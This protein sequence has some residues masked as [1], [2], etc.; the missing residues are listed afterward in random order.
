MANDLIKTKRITRF[1][2]GTPGDPGFPGRP[3][4][5]ARVTKFKYDKR[6]VAGSSTM[7]I[8]FERVKF[9]TG[10]SSIVGASWTS[11]L[12]VLRGMVG[13]PTLGAAAAHYTERL[14]PMVIQYS[15]VERLVL[16]S[17]GYSL[18]PFVIPV[19]WSDAWIVEQV[20]EVTVIPAKPAIP[21]RP[22]KPGTPP[23]I[24]YDY[25]LGW[26]GVARSIRALPQGWIGTVEFDVGTVVGAMVG[27]I[28]KP[29][30]DTIGAYG[31]S[32][33][34]SGVAIG[35]GKICSVQRGVRDTTVAIPVTGTDHVKGVVSA[36]GVEWFANDQFITRT[37]LNTKGEVVLYA[38]LYRGDDTVL[39]PK[40]TDGLPPDPDIEPGSAK[41]KLY[42]A[43]LKA[44]N[45]E[46]VRGIAKLSPLTLLASDYKV[47][48][49]GLQMRAVRVG[50]TPLPRGRVSIPALQVRGSH[51]R[52][53][54]AARLVLRSLR[55]DG[56][57]M[58]EDWV[59][60]YSMGTAFIPPLTVRGTVRGGQSARVEMQFAPLISSGSE[61]EHAE[62][63]AVLGPLATAGEGEILTH[64][65]R[66]MNYVGPSPAVEESMYVSIV[67][68]ERMGV[69]DPVVM[70]AVISVDAKERLSVEDMV[71]VSATIVEEAL[72]QIGASVK[73][74]ALLFRLQ[75]DQ[76]IPVEQG[77]AWA[78]NTATNA[79]TRYEGYAFNSFM[80]I[81][82]KHF[83]VQPRGV[84]LLEGKD[85]A[86]LPIAAGVNLGKQD[87]GTQAL[88]GLSAVHA[89]VS[90]TGTLFLRVG[91]GR[92]TWTYRARRVDPRLRTQRFDPGK[93]LRTNYFDF[94]LVSE[95]EFELD[96]V[97]FEVVASQRRI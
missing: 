7:R 85:D 64:L 52:R 26:M 88:K 29:A 6:V 55:A 24:T 76:I 71:E 34:L 25:Q 65:V 53:D 73:H 80:V 66:A 5:P 39:N 17:M 79:S 61:L 56:V 21:A 96:S 78:V 58:K 2:P 28:D 12:D 22:P 68:A 63:R 91:D 40:F 18:A 89:G 74:T 44:S 11:P 72:E 13:R 62:G 81:G 32:P 48:Q 9:D 35:D 3:A 27:F 49:G 59:P 83:G 84:Y 14:G 31:A 69:Q 50:S 15:E 45:Q 77:S 93:G 97:R 20:T 46:P 54:G 36:S 30:G 43:A 70:A 38:S 8:D 82:G 57:M 90:A 60:K 47:A 42:L 87:F 4:E 75:G 1:E 23:R 33:I 37:P 86:G 41:G 19:E 16:G 92:N 95:G 51:V 94:E 10:G 67:V